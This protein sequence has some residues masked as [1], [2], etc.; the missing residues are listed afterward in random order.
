MAFATEVRASFSCAGGV[1]Y[2]FTCYFPW[3]N[4]NSSI[5]PQPCW[6]LKL[7]QTYPCSWLLTCLSRSDIDWCCILILVIFI[8]IRFAHSTPGDKRFFCQRFLDDELYLPF[9]W[10]CYLKLHLS[11]QVNLIKIFSVKDELYMSV[12]RV[13]LLLL[14]PWVRLCATRSRQ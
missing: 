1:S 8:P 9:Q 2:L 14:V 4:L 10:R 7:V 12:S 3:S 5:T 6:S 11:I 13:S